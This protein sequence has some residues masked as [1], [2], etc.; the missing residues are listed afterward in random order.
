MLCYYPYL[1]FLRRLG[2]GEGVVSN[3]KYNTLFF[4]PFHRVS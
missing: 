3:D 1:A 4:T 2:Q